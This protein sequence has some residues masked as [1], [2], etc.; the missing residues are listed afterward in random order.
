M[1][2]YTHIG[3]LGNAV[4]DAEQVNA[5]LNAV[6]RCRSNI[7]KDPKTPMDMVRSVRTFLDEPRLR[8]EPPELCVLS[9]AGHSIQRAGEVYLVPTDAKLE[10]EAEDCAIE[11]L[12][13]GKLL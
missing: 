10:D 13:L 3:P 5:K 8:E 6:P 2:K 12:S 1:G 9:Y 7:V 11:C 4:R